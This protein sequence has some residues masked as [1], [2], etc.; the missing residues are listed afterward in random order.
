MRNSELVL[1]D[2]TLKTL[3]GTTHDQDNSRLLGTLQSDYLM[4][5]R[6][7]K[8]KRENLQRHYDIF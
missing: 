6:Y 2:R 8:L 3:L 7:T 4:A 1:L 5:L